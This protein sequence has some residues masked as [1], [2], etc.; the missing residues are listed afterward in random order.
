MFF[1]F[2]LLINILPLLYPLYKI[3]K[4]KDLNIFDFLIV[5]QAIFFLFIPAVKDIET[6]DEVLFRYFVIYS[7]FNYLILGISRYTDKR[8]LESIVNMTRYL[9]RYSDFKIGI[10]GQILLLLSL[11]VIFVYYL[12]TQALVLRFEETT[13]IR[14]YAQSTIYLFLAALYFVVRLLVSL[15]IVADY[16]N[17]RFNL[18]NIFI[19][20]VFVILALLGVRRDLIFS[21]LVFFIILY[22]LKRDAFNVRFTIISL[23]I[24]FFVIAVYFPFYNIIRSSPIKFT[25]HSPIK[26]VVEIVDYGLANYNNKIEKAEESTDKRSLGLYNAFYKAIEKNPEWNWGSITC[27]FIDMAIPRFLNP[28]KGG[29][30][31]LITR[32]IGVNTDIADSVL[33]TGVCEFGIFGGLYAVFLFL[34][35]FIIY[36]L[37]SNL[38]VTYTSSFLIPVYIVFSLFDMCWNVEVIPTALFSWFFSSIPM[39][40]ILYLLERFRV[41]EVIMDNAIE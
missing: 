4:R 26:S 16:V 22:S 29:S 8:N 31:D 36:S 35:V 37:Y 33:L 38:L 9:S 1:Y 27:S 17:H 41:L 6:N 40:L 19:F 5:F 20:V 39:I 10:L 32:S 23:C 13:G 2:I 30:G 24:G 28:N 3:Y 18:I 12:P 14:T 25:T 7:S 15:I 34:T 11:V 21:L